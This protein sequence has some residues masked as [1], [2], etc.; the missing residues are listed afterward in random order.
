MTALRP[1][2]VTT[3][4]SPLLVDLSRHQLSI[5]PLGLPTAT[6]HQVMEILA[7]AAGCP[8]TADTDTFHALLNGDRQ[9]SLWVIDL[10][11]SQADLL[12]C[13]RQADGWRT[14]TGN[15]FDATLIQ[16]T[17]RPALHATPANLQGYPVHLHLDQEQMT[18]TGMPVT[19]AGR[20][21]AAWLCW[22]GTL[23]DL[24]PDRDPLQRAAT[25]ARHADFQQVCL[26]AARPGVDGQVARTHLLSVLATTYTTSLLELPPAPEA[27]AFDLLLTLYSPTPDPLP[28]YVLIEG[29]QLCAPDRIRREPAVGDDQT[30]TA[31]TDAL[32]AQLSG[33]LGVA[34]LLHAGLYLS[35]D[36]VC[37]ANAQTPLLWYSLTDLHPDGADG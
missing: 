27:T 23:P 14:G 29:Q 31:Y 26:D 16:D 12:T 32:F 21:L 34:D 4:V 17:I 18:V 15:V 10:H 24:S 35:R 8:A 25:E 9:R 22:C 11:G 5:L 20:L 1:D 13:Y 6:H 19:D 30:P 37:A 33:A 2:P 3:H 28:A 36:S 7:Q